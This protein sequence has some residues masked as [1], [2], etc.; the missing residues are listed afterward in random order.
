MIYIVR[1]IS[2]LIL[3]LLMAACTTEEIIERNN[4]GET[5]GS[6]VVID[7]QAGNEK[8]TRT[9]LTGS[10]SI[11]HVTYVHLYVFE[12]SDPAS[13]CIGAENVEWRQPVGPTARQK[14]MMKIKL[15]PYETYTLLAVGLDC[16]LDADGKADL[17]T[18]SAAT[19]GLPDGIVAG[20]PA[21]PDGTPAVVG[22]SLSEA[23]A[24][25]TAAKTQADI[26]GSELFAGS[27][28][29]QAASD[30]TAMTTIDLWR[31][32]AGVQGYFTNI[33]TGV[34]RIKLI[35][36]KEQYQDVP[37]MK[38]TVGDHGSTPLTGSTVLL[39]IPV[40]T[41]ELQKETL[42][43]DDGT[44]Y[45]KLPGSVLQSV[46]TLPLDAPPAGTGTLVLKTYKGD[47]EEK[48]Y[49]VNAKLQNGMLV[50]SFPILANHFY[51]LGIKN[52][53]IDEPIDLGG[54][55]DETVFIRVDG[56]WQADVDIPM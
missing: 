1:H 36:Y 26:A 41:D 42:T 31:R 38:R 11:Q 6:G 48:T 9:T 29:I 7:F 3:L 10:D 39:D 21:T 22:T 23:V 14:Y 37:L 27:V 46:Y 20:T 56:S 43:A 49:K 15:T 33:P 34:T 25:L 5:Q 50:N 19:Y 16:R 12:G 52:S 55:I 24:R 17:T 28:V 32:V 51:T 18:N 8:K 44:T 13:T 40:T 54:T 2:W 45:T 35:L 4:G 53:T 30:G 47:V